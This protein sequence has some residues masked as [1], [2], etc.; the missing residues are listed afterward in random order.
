MIISS[1]ITNYCGVTDVPM[2][3]FLVEELI[4]NTP[5]SIIN[6]KYIFLHHE[7]INNWVG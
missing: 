2:V 5:N 3:I 7:E 6:A 4:K 1:N